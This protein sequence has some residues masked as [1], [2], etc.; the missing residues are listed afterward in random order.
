[1]D[2]KQ[3]RIRAVRRAAEQGQSQGLAVSR[4]ATR[5]SKHGAKKRAWEKKQSG[6]NGAR[7]SFDG[8]QIDE[9]APTSELPAK[10]TSSRGRGRRSQPKVPGF[11]FRCICI[12]Q[13]RAGA[14]AGCGILRPRARNA[15]SNIAAEPKVGRGGLGEET[16]QVPSACCEHA[17]YRDPMVWDKAGLVL[18]LTHAW[19]FR[20]KP[21][22]N[23]GAGL[24]SD[25]QWVPLSCRQRHF[26][27][28]FVLYEVRRG[29]SSRRTT[30]ICCAA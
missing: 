27:V 16:Q 18:Q 5:K 24:A 28:K 6:L 2:S 21:S 8:S 20:T 19:D 12:R 15:V 26:P 23:L 22:A 13:R 3:T 11:P 4:S 14:G 29:T 17:C 1:M 25:R 10:S 30:S 9:G 7:P